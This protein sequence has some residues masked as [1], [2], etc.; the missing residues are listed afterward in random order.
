MKRI[1]NYVLPVILLLGWC[2]G[3]ANWYIGANLLNYSGEL[4]L[5]D[6]NCVLEKNGTIYFGLISSSRIQ[7][8]DTDGKYKGHIQSHSNGRHYTF[9]IDTKGNNRWLGFATTGVRNTL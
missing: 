8:Y 6:I 1:F 9:D 2:T 3:V 7:I 5:T 4:P